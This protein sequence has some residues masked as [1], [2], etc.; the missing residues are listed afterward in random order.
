MA[1]FSPNVICTRVMPDSTTRQWVRLVEPPSG[2]VRLHVEGVDPF[3]V[4]GDIVV[5]EMY[6]R[7]LTAEEIQGLPE[8]ERNDPAHHSA[9]D[10]RVVVRGS[11]SQ[12]VSVEPHQDVDIELLCSDVPWD[13]S[14]K[15]WTGRLVAGLSGSAPIELPLYFAVGQGGGMQPHVSAGQLSAWMD[16]GQSRDMIFT[17]DSAPSGAEVRACLIGGGPTIQSSEI[18]VW[19]MEN[20]TYREALERGLLDG[21]SEEELELVKANGYSHNAELAHAAG[22]KPVRVAAGKQVRVD[23]PCR[24]PEN[25][26]GVERAVLAVI[27]PPWK[28]VEVSVTAIVQS[29][30]VRLDQDT[31]TVA[32][33]GSTAL[34]LTVSS[35]LGAAGYVMFKLEGGNNHLTVPPPAPLVFGPE[36]T[37]RAWLPLSVSPTAPLGPLGTAHLVALFSAGGVSDAITT[38]MDV[39]VTVIPSRTEVLV[40]PTSISVPTGSFGL[41]TVAAHSGGG[42][43]EIRLTPGPLPP[44]VSVESA[45]MTLDP[46]DTEVQRVV[47]I[48]IQDNA[49]LVTGLPLGIE[50][51]S[52]NGQHRGTDVSELTILQRPESRTFTEPVITPAGVPLGGEVEFEIHSDGSA[53]FRGHM[54]ATGLF[55]YKFTVRAVLRSS[56][57]VIALIHQISGRVYGWDTAGPRQFDWDEDASRQVIADMW[58]DMRSGSIVVSRS[59]EMTGFLGEAAELAGDVLE[60]AVVQSLLLPFGPGGQ[61][62]AALVLVGSEIGDVADTSII[63]PGGLCG[64]MAAGGAAFLLGPTMI[65]PAFVGGVLIG[66]TLIRHRR[67]NA[68][69]EAMARELFEDTLPWDKIRLTNLSGQNGQAFVTPSADGTILVNLGVAFDSPLTSVDPPKGYPV[70]GQLL[71][72]ELTHAWQIAHKS[73]KSEYFW[74][75]ALDKMSGDASYLYG[76]PGPPWRTFGLEAQASLVEGWWAGRLDESVGGFPPGVKTRPRK[77]ETDPYFRYISENIRMGEPL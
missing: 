57:G 63:G 43:K 12:S 45:T 11:G 72:H 9:L 70:P 33:G 5:S 27:A 41:L 14:P 44:G 40:S 49:R 67:L 74:K 68:A 39:K 42:F 6:W 24:A 58:Q 4:V 18:S 54:R 52:N 51:N 46:T 22:T 71:M 13:G 29:V 2:S 53:R 31:F 77:S 16:P 25:G 61:S 35:G 21:M 48:D 7:P 75:A 69:E 23:I 55:S 3:V 34:D 15:W 47:R 59:S 65:V 73:F 26:G 76:P 20:L 32:Q 60:F 10:T 30:S 1:E 64:V 37:V 66:E 36:E 50:W 28:P 56:S 19:G 62:L 38:S 8:D 17:I